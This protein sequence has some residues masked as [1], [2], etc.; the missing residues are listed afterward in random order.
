MKRITEVT[1]ESFEYDNE[2]RVDFIDNKK[3]ELFEGWL[4]KH[5]ICVKIY[6]FGAPYRFCLNIE[7]FIDLIKT[8]LENENNIAAY[9]DDL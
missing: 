7:S 9:E 8:N 5:N 2:Y 6:M 3:E 1:T 4:Y